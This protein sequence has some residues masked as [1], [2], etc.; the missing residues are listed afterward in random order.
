MWS[1]FV[2]VLSP[3]APHLGEELWEKLGHNNTIAYENW[4]EANENFT[5]DD[6]KTIVVMVNGKKRDTFEAEPGSSDDA[7]KETAFAREG[8]KKFTDCH[9]IVKC[10]VVKDK[11]VNIVI[12]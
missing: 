12:K 2:K 5:K 11:L 6:V 7:L 10:I 9:E 4:P 8:V 1:D 3:Y